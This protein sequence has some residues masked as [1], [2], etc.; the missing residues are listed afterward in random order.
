MF[1]F[2]DVF[3]FMTKRITTNYAIGEVNNILMDVTCDGGD[4]KESKD[5]SQAIFHIHLPISSLSISS[6][7]PYSFPLFPND[8]YILK[9]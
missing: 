6:L 3:A 1:D 9:A 5:G 4:D 8:D 7:L 2:T